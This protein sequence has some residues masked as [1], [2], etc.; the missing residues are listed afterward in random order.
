MIMEHILVISIIVSHTVLLVFGSNSHQIFDLS[1]D[2][3]E[4]MPV[5]ED[6]IPPEI[7]IVEKNEGYGIR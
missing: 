7:S 2:Y 1:H 6:D 5:M 3:Y 4:N